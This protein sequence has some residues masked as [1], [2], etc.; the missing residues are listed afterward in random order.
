LPNSQAH[1]EGGVAGLSYVWEKGY[2]GGSFQGFNNNY[3]T[4]AERDVTDHMSQRRWDLAGAFYEP[5]NSI[6]SLKWKFGHSDYKQTEFE[7]PQ[8]GTTFELD[9]LNGRMEALHNPLGPFEGAIGYEVRR[10]ELEVTGDEASLPPSDSLVNSAFLFEQVKWEKVRLQFGG[11]LDHSELDASANARFGPARSRNFTTGSGAVGMVYRPKEKYSGALNFSYTQRAPVQKELLSNG[12]DIGSGYFL[13]G[14]PEL[15]PERSY[16]L[17][18]TLR[19]ETGK[20][21][22]S[23]TFFYTHFENFITPAPRGAI[24]PTFNL[25]IYD[26]KGL[27]TDFLGAEAS[28]LFHVLEQDKHKVL[29]ELKTDFVRATNADTDDPL[30]RIPPWR[31][32]AELSYDWNNR[33]GASVEVMHAQAQHETAANELPTDDYTLLGVAVTYRLSTAP[34]TW[35]LI[36]KGTNLLDEEARLHTSFIKDVAPLAGRGA[37]VA[38]RASF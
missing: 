36:F 37:M 20:I 19:K 4:V 31:F 12:P 14:D 21:T 38:L 6:Q 16:G 10:D 18:L 13:V 35:D 17:D 15:K 26:V 11:R 7:G 25:P 24:D 23:A 32:G 8:P 34:V 29:F 1:S 5:M 33:L 2:A 3:G 28:V 22:G 27:P 30:P 9:A